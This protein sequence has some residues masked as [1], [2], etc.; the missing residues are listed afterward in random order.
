MYI[1]TQKARSIGIEG[2]FREMVELNT[3]GTD[4]QST[5]QARKNYFM[6][7]QSNGSYK[8]IDARIR[9]TVT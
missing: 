4:K 8:K 6:I 3:Y 1:R 5:M 9:D 2:K 7:H